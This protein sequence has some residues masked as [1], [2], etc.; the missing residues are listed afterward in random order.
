MPRRDLARNGLP[1]RVPFR[2]PDWPSDRPVDHSAFRIRLPAADGRRTRTRLQPEP[3]GVQSEPIGAGR[4]VH[5][6]DGAFRQPPGR[7]APSARIVCWI[8]FAWFSVSVL[9]CGHSAAATIRVRRV[10]SSPVTGSSPGRTPCPDSQTRFILDPSSTDAT[11]YQIGVLPYTTTRSI[12]PSHPADPLTHQH[13]PTATKGP[14]KQGLKA[15][16]ARKHRHHAT[17]GRSKRG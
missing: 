1:D 3:T 16:L 11:L 4:A 13:R 10:S 6:P 2:R 15:Y 5:R 14:L 9:L 7:A 12:L 8:V 17:K